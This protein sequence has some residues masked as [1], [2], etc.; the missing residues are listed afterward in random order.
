MA[1]DVDKL[2]SKLIFIDFDDKVV[3]AKFQ[4]VEKLKQAI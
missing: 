3:F 1:Q 4:E 2:Y